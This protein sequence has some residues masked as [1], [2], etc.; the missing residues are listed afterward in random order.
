MQSTYLLGDAVKVTP[1]LEAG[2]QDGD[3][4]N[5]YFPEGVWVNLYTPAQIIN[6]KGVSQLE[7]QST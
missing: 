1:A 4:F 3:S 7:I 5:A 2:K 6:G